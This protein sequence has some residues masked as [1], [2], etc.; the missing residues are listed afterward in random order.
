M[1]ETY[2]AIYEKHNKADYLIMY[3]SYKKLLYRVKLDYI[4]SYMVRLARTSHKNGYKQKLQLALNNDIK[5]YLLKYYKVECLG[6][7]NDLIKKS[8]KYNTGYQVQR[9]EGIRQKDRIY[10]QYDNVPFYKNGDIQDKQGNQIQVKYENA[11]ICLI[12]TL[13]RLEALQ[14][15]KNNNNNNNNNNNKEV[16]KMK[17]VF[18][19]YSYY[20]TNVTIK[21]M[22]NEQ[23]ANNY[24]NKYLHNVRYKIINTTSD[25]QIQDLERAEC[26]LRNSFIRHK[27]Y[28]NYK[29]RIKRF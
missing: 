15:S 2:L 17:K 10:K 29:P 23:H 4:P 27:Y 22:N 18:L 28:N 5:K 7:K 19:M 16:N 26:E 1:V 21:E 24:I 12:D 14:V 6:Y 11:Q 20:G 25:T 8:S 9:L 3:F 13:A